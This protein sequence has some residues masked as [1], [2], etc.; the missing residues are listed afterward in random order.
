M[1]GVFA[2]I[3]DALRVGGGGRL[4]FPESWGRCFMD[5]LAALDHGVLDTAMVETAAY[6]LTKQSQLP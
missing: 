4:R 5:T 3:A 6:V 1:A 2:R